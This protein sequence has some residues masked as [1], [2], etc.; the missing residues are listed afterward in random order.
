MHTSNL[1]LSY[2]KGGFSGRVALNYVGNYLADVTDSPDADVWWDTHAQM[3][4]Y[5]QQRLTKNL[6]LY[7]TALNVNN[8]R[9]RGYL[10]IQ[11]RPEHDE[12][13]SW[14]GTA[15]LRLSF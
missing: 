11:A 1:A 2:E 15:G 6:S 7:V 12:I 9:D 8:S 3:D 4:V 14:W 5:A 10:S 13:L